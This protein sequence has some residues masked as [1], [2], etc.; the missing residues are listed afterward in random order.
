[1][2]IKSYG[3]AIGNLRAK[4]NS[5][6]KKSD[7]LTFAG[8]ED[9]EQLSGYLRDKGFSDRT[10]NDDVPQLLKNS[11]SNLWDYLNEISPDEGIFRPFLLENDFHNLKAAIKAT[12]K[13]TEPDNYFLLPATVDTKLLKTSALERNFENLPE[14]MRNPAERAME[15]L[16]S[17]GDSQLCDAVID[18]AYMNEQLALVGAKDYSCKLSMEIITKTVMFKNIKAALRCAKAQKSGAFID[19]TLADTKHPSKSALK[20]AALNGEDAVLEL[21]AKCGKELADAA[22]SY[23]KSPAEFERFCDDAVMETARKAKRI[24]FGFEP[25]I[26]YYMARK[27]EIQNVRII[28][29]GIKTGQREEKITERLRALYG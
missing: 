10:S 4:E 12:V 16:L 21:M 22:E 27:T 28:Y 7:L 8:A 19:E 2:P 13:N 17:N 14:F 26:G 6:L 9:T 11:A 15:I 1:M 24:T 3:F 25:I 23:K 20:T 29:S 5:L 18:K